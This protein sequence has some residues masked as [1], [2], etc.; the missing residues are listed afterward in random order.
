MDLFNFFIIYVGSL[1][2]LTLPLCGPSLRAIDYLSSNLVHRYIYLDY[3]VVHE[4]AQHELVN[5]NHSLFRSNFGVS[6][7]KNLAN[8]PCKVIQSQ[9]KVHLPIV[10][11]GYL[12]KKMIYLT[13]RSVSSLNNPQNSEM[14]FCENMK[15]TC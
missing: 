6:K 14:K 7:F 8:M 11:H 13:L 15:L 2:V 5:A 3:F 12:H 10:A 9:H 1:F 4:S